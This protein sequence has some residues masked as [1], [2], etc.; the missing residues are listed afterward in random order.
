MTRIVIIEDEDAASDRLEDM[1]Q[2]LSGDMKVV[3]KLD[4]VTDSIEYLSSE[5]NFDLILMDIHLSDGNSFDIFK[6]V[7]I[8]KPIIFTTAY[9]EYAI[10][11]FKQYSVDYLLKPIKKDL[12]DV[13]LKKYELYYKTPAPDYSQLVSTEANVKRWLIKI[14]NS[15]KIISYSDVAYYYTIEKI[16]YLMAF[17]GK[18]YPIDYSLEHIETNVID[19]KYFRI[20]R[21]YII[22]ENAVGKMGTHTKSRVK[23]NLLPTN[24]EVIVSTERSPQFKKW[25]IG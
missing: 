2:S 15:I 13:A 3:K 7:Q 22:H 9:D 21:Q 4:S 1:L 12:L 18:K 8:T 24:E 11:A 23:I 20:N 14:G 5:T 19:A 25:L 16:T 10:D 17:D 6:Y